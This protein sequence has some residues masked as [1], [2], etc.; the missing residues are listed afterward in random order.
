MTGWSAETMKKIQRMSSTPV[1]PFRLHPGPFDAVLVALQGPGRSPWP[2]EE[3]MQEHA[4]GEAADVGPP[5]DPRDLR[6]AGQGDRPA[7][8]LRQGPEQ[9]VDDRGDLDEQRVE[10]DRDQHDDAGARE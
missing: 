1:A 7:E 3:R 10:E 6:R 5:G 8:E 9:Q 2:H 4:R